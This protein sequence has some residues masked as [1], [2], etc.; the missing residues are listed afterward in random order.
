MNCWICDKKIIHGYHYV[1]YLC[2]NIKYVCSVYCQCKCVQ[3][4]KY[5]QCTTKKEIYLNP[6]PTNEK[7]KTH[8]GC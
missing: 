1:C 2:H 7:S 5:E 3:S 8:L 4:H 6:G